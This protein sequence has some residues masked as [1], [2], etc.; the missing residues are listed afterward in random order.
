M[1]TALFVVAGGLAISVTVLVA[2]SPGTAQPILNESGKP[3]PGSI[4]EKTFVMIN[5]VEQGMFIKGANESNPV[6]LY[7]HGGMP[8]YFLT[9]KHP[10]GF[11]NE[12][13]VCWWEQ[14][15]SGL[16]YRQD[17]PPDTMN[18]A[19]LVADTIEVTNYLRGRFGQKKIYL[20]AHSG[21]T[22]LGVLVAAEAPDLY[23]AYIGVAQ[24]SDQLA[25]EIRAHDYMVHEFHR[26]GDQRM[27]RKLQAAPVTAESGTPA[28]YLAVRDRAMHTLGIGTTHDMKSVFRGIFLASLRCRE[29][30]LSEKINMWRGKALSG[31]SF[32]WQTMLTT[33]LVDRV[34]A[35][36][37]PVYFLHG[38]FDFTCSYAVAK[39]Y[40]D[41]LSA[42]LKGF[43][44]FDE[45]AHSPIF[46]ELSRVMQI[47][48]QDVLGGKNQLADPNGI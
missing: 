32:L 14:R 26:I 28:A 13:T 42:P 39:T 7:L 46:E 48:R 23:Q 9:R 24:M 6:L 44:T 2:W 40:F 41:S 27:V 17:I 22:F 30:T 10:V 35:L 16:S 31:V 47:L 34:P 25:S 1:L 45:S 8:D 29:Y 37:V 36:D 43:Y 20:M 21:G 33:N 38:V 5:G 4:S 12:F 15:G 19:Q 18:E 3:R 11:E